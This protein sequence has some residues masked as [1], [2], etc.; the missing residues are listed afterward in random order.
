[1]IN[2]TKYIEKHYLLPISY[3]L[4]LLVTR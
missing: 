3:K 2:A 4:Q 1:L